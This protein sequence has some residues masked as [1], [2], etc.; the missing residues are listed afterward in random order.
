M[1]GRDFWL[2]WAL[3]L[4][5]LTA[6]TG[7]ITDSGGNRSSGASSSAQTGASGGASG[8]G[9]SVQNVD[10][11]QAPAMDCSKPDIGDSPLRRITTS[12]YLH[13]VRDLL[14]VDTLPP[15]SLPDDERLG[16]FRSNLSTPVGDLDVEKYVTLAASLATTAVTNIDQLV[17]C[18]RTAE[19]DAVCASSFIQRF[20]RRAFRRPLAQTELQTYLDLYTK[21]SDTGFSNGIRLVLSAM[22]SSPNFLY[23]VEPST[24]PALAKLDGY[25]LAARMSLFLWDSGPDDALLDAA[26]RGDLDNDAGLTTQVNRLLSDARANDAIGSFHLQ[27]LGLEDL[28]DASKDASLYPLWNADLAS[29]MQ[30]DTARFASYVL[31]QADGQLSTLLTAPYAFPDANLLP[32]YGLK[33]GSADPNAPT[34]LDPTERAGILTQPGFL[35]ANAHVNQ[36]APIL[37]AK[38]ILTNLLCAAPQPPPPNLN[39][40]PPDPAPGLS[41]RARFAAHVQD[42]F[43]AGCHQQLDDLGFGLE[44]YDAVGAYRTQDSG[45]PV[46]ASGQVIGTRD[47]NGPFT[48]AI[49]LAKRLSTS[50]QVRQ[51]VTKEWF[52]FGVGRGPSTADA[53]TLYQ[54]YQSFSGSQFNLRALVVALVKSDSFRNRKDATQ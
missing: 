3:P 47:A 33:Q 31:L 6:C 36:S 51:C 22:L 7:V 28:T 50:D 34:Q 44:N 39:I 38:A 23:Q 11:S 19:G 49:E 53:C 35:S 12:Q 40:T 13:S 9:D 14:G 16:T 52:E 21:Y 30:R 17:A 29:A 45:Q 37:R 25:E 26:G 1:L 18:D 15:N 8:S 20:G 54:A 10:L 2:E 5:S 24:G 43:C 48:G 32:I 46:D 42:P 41:T 27:W 4:L